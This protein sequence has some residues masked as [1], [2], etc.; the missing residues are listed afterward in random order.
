MKFAATIRILFVLILALG[1]IDQHNSST[2][3]SPFAQQELAGHQATTGSLSSHGLIDAEHG[4]DI[5]SEVPGITSTPEFI[6][7]D[8]VTL[9][10]P[11]PVLTGPSPCWQ[12][13]ELRS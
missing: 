11:N 12:P 1:F 10:V 4:G 6:L 5:L 2:F 8:P 13:P 7:L 3:S 9:P